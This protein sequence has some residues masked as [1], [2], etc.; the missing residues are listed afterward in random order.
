MANFGTKRAV[1]AATAA[2]VVAGGTGAAVAA[3][4]GG[5]GPSDFLDSVAKHLGVSPRS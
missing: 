3:S 5:S 1:M 2:L 4:G